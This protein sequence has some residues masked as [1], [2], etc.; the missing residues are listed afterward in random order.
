MKKKEN[1]A[2]GPGFQDKQTQLKN[3]Y[4]NYTYSDAKSLRKFQ[5]ELKN[6]F[7]SKLAGRIANGLERKVQN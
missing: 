6:T 1:P 7:L 5:S 3:R 4:M 2:G